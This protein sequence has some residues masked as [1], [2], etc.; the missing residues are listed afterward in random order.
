MSEFLY[1]FVLN[2]FQFFSFHFQW[3]AFPC[4]SPE[5]NLTLIKIP[6]YTHLFELPQAHLKLTLFQ[7]NLYRVSKTI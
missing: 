6:V 1:P 2:Y 4:L 7:Y 5:E 3:S